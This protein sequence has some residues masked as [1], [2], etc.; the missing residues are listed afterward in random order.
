IT[1]TFADVHLPANTIDTL[2]TLVS[3][4][5]LKPDAFT[6]GILHEHGMRGSLLFGPPGTGKTHVAR[7]L[8]REA[9]AHMLLLKP[10]D[11]LHCRVGESEKTV[12]AIFSLARR[13][14]P[15]IVFIDELDALFAQ[16]SGD[17]DREGHRSML[18]EFMQEMDG[19]LSKNENV[20]VIGATNRPFDLDDALIRRLPCRLLLDLPD[21]NEREG[22][23]MQ[24][25]KILL[26]SETLDRDV[27]VAKIAK[28]TNKF[29][30]SDL[31]RAL[32]MAC[33]G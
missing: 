20:I 22:A 7:A 29:S 18:T 3:L 4:P 28:E 6:H 23:C 2:R 11:I 1:T 5:L 14:T 19:L 8:A 12:Q 16:R 17:R 24:I 27:D 10:S 15:C 13:L 31:K 33:S 32:I 25:L 26:R 9:D 21:E 30:G